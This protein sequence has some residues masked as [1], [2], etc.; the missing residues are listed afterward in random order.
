MVVPPQSYTEKHILR[1]IIGD[2]ANLIDPLSCP[3]DFVDKTTTAL[4]VHMNSHR[5]ERN[6]KLIEKSDL[7]THIGRY[8]FSLYNW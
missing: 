7:Y 4:S 5:D 2:S 1:Y 8:I 6:N 3:N